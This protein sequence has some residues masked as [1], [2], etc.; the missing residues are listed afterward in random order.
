MSFVNH[1]S[2]A[3]LTVLWMV[4]QGWHVDQN[5]LK[6]MK[7]TF[8]K[9]KRLLSEAMFQLRM[10][11]ITQLKFAYAAIYIFIVCAH[12]PIGCVPACFVRRLERAHMP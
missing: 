2:V 7:V 5:V 1:G 4:V 3:L 11:K 12:S 6:P 10:R 9:G 8:L